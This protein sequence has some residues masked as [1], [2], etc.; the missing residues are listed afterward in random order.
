MKT[1]L[2]AFAAALLIPAIAL[3]DDVPTGSDAFSGSQQTITGGTIAGSTLFG[4]S[5]ASSS[6]FASTHGGSASGAHAD[7]E[8]TFT[9]ASDHR[10]TVTFGESETGALGAAIA[11]A[12]EARANYG[13]Q[14]SSAHA[15]VQEDEGWGDWWD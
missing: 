14:F 3:A 4:T 11:V 9:W 2:S 13:E 10:T 1:M 6:N 15:E 8:D 12:G 7:D 5:E